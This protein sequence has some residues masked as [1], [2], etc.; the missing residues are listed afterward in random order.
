[1]PSATS[2]LAERHV[3]DHIDKHRRLFVIEGPAQRKRCSWCGRSS[4]P[5]AAKEAFIACDSCSALPL[6][7]T[8][9]EPDR[10]SAARDFLKLNPVFEKTYT[11]STKG[12]RGPTSGDSLEPARKHGRSRNQH[13]H[14]SANSHLRLQKTF[15][16][17]AVELEHREHGRTSALDI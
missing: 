4:P 16:R 11:A 2:S 12:R 14:Q 13:T 5:E 10:I 9:A 3:P 17:A 7:C 6:Y 15:R 8:R 1:M